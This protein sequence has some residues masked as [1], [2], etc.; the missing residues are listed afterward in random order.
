MRGTRTRRVWSN[1]SERVHGEISGRIEH[2]EVTQ[3]VLSLIDRR[4]GKKHFTKTGWQKHSA[5]YPKPDILTTVDLT[6]KVFVVTGANSGIGKELTKYLSSRVRVLF[7]FVL[8]AAQAK[9]QC[10]GHLITAE[11]EGVHDLPKQRTG[12]TGEDRD[13]PGAQG[14]RAR[15]SGREPTFVCSGFVWYRFSFKICNSESYLELCSV[16]GQKNF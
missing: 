5:K 2:L 4:Y 11:G 7:V 9:T 8:F 1:D 14:Q 16:F 10:L 6:G 15:H 3:V 13:P 12:R